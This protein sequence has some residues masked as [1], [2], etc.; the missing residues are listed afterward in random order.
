MPGLG[1]RSAASSPIPRTREGHDDC[2]W[3]VPTRLRIR[4]RRASSLSMGLFI[5][6]YKLL[7][8]N[9][10]FAQPSIS[11]EATALVVEQAR[12]QKDKD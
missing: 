6:L 3:E 5:W 11:L 10:G 1:R 12:S 9:A 4:A 2:G 8:L 7:Q